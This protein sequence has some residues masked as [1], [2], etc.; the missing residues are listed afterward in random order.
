MTNINLNIFSDRSYLRITEQEFTT[1]P[2]DVRI[3]FLLIR[4]INYYKI[5]NTKVTRR[6]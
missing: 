2:I 5:H 1:L 6:S 3:L 4:I